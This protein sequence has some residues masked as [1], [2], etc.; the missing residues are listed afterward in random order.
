MTEKKSRL[1]PLADALSAYLDKSG[2]AEAAESRRVLTEWRERVGDRIADVATPVRMDRGTLIVGVR[3]SAWLM[4][5]R[6]ME[7][8]LVERLNRG[9]GESGIDGI[10]L[11]LGNAG[12]E[13]GAGRGKSERSGADG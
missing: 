1:E 3:S 2:I 7:K 8:R 5:L 10:R 9:L 11:V 4:E 12:T 6:L 13:G